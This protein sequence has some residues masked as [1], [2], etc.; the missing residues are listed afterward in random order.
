MSAASVHA[1]HERRVNV[2]VE[3]IMEPGGSESIMNKPVLH[4]RGGQRML[5]CRI[6]RGRD[7]LCFTVEWERMLRWTEADPERRLTHSL[8][9][10]AVSNVGRGIRHG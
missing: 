4:C 5:R 9:H 6:V 10:A 3:R 8:I 1:N 2:D 7:R